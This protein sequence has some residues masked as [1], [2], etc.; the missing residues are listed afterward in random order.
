MKIVVTIPAY[1]EEESIGKVIEDIKEV[2]SK[3]GYNYKLLIVDDG[4]KDKTAEIARQKGAIVVSHYANLGLAEAF[5]TEIKKS[6]EMGAG[7]IVHTDADGQYQAK[8]IPLLVEEIKRGYDLVLGDRF[9]GGIETM[10]LIKKLGNKAFSRAISKIIN[11]KVNDC[12]TGFRAFTN[13]VAS[14]VQI[15][16]SHTYTQE[17]IIRAVKMGYKIKEV[18]TYFSARKGKS[19]LLKNPF[20]YAVKGWINILRIQRDYNPL[21][22]FGVFGIWL[23][24]VGLIIGIWLVKNFLETGQVGHVPSTILCMLLITTGLQAIFFGFLA[25]MNKK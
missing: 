2:M 17:Q 5:R 6:L 4:S 22:F 13:E 23:I 20:E 12:Q 18:P 25:D 7:I 21:K 1:N 24:L 8:D 11:A 14:R 10:P 9:S 19:R 16:S 15:I 3:K